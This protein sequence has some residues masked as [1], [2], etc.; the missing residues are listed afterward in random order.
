M[1]AA[2]TG[3]RAS[4]VDPGFAETEF[5]EVRYAGDRERAKDVY[6]G[7]EPLSAGDVADAVHFVV[8]RPAHVN[9]IN[10]VLVPTAQRGG[11]VVDR[12]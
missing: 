12:T 8:T 10:L 1:L 3:I 11:Y 4:S 2:G 7:F 9:A 6:Q 5:S